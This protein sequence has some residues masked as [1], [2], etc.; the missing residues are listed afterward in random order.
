LNGRRDAGTTINLKG[1]KQIMANKL[2][3]LAGAMSESQLAATVRASAQQIWL[4]GLGASSTARKERNKVFE[5]LVKEGEVIQSLTQKAVA[6]RLKKKAAR[7]SGTRSRLEQV[8][9][10][11]VARALTRFGIPTRKGIDTLSQRLV[12][13]TA[14]I[15]KIAAEVSRKQAAVKSTASAASRARSA[16]RA[17]GQPPVRRATPPA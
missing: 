10:D 4:A 11:S 5:A 12:A 16:D 15:D 6:A 1:R 7:A 3:G 9:E 13:L 17:P 2:K 8:V 14:L